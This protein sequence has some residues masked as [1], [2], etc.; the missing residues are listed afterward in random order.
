MRTCTVCKKSKQKIE[1]RFHKR[2]SSTGGFHSKQCLQCISDDKKIWVELNWYKVNESNKRY[3]RDNAHIIRGN[4]LS[5]YWPGTDW[6]SATEKYAELL[7]AQN[8]VCA[9]CGCAE[10][11]LHPSTGTVW[12]LAVDH[13]HTTNKVRGLLCNA[14]NRGLGLLDDSVEGLQRAVEYLKKA[15]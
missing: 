10:T 5:K 11:R 1:F 2:N 14:C 6:K 12:D 3:N 7:T 4:K 8:G 9:L 15:A 13:C